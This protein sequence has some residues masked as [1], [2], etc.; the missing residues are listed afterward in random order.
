MIKTQ[1]SILLLVF[2]AL[3]FSFTAC[4]KVEPPYMNEDAGQNDEDTVVVR[5]ILLEEFTGHQCPNCP[6]GMK[7]ANQLKSVYGDRFLI[8]SIHTGLFA[9][10]TPGDFENDY[11]TEAG[12]GIAEFFGINQFPVGIVNRTEFDGSTMMSPS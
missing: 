11:R 3:I 7:T 4:D 9:R 5:K 6:E 12:D 1:F 10:P 2:S 8:M